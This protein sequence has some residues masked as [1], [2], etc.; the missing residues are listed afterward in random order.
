M[1]YD[2]NEDY[3]T[4]QSNDSMTI[5]SYVIIAGTVTALLTLVYYFL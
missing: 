2:E 4:R 5:F 1:I 3:K